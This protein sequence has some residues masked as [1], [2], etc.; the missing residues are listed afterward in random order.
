MSRKIIM[1]NYKFFLFF[2][3]INIVLNFLIIKTII[4]FPSSSSLFRFLKIL[5]INAVIYNEEKKISSLIKIDKSVRY[6][7]IWRKNKNKF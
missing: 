4:F 7:F 3:K 6:E 2:P 5:C 1:N